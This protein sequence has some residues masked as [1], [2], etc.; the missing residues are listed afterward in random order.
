MFQLP[1]QQAWKHMA[2]GG[3]DTA[4]K[5]DHNVA[6]E[7]GT[8]HDPYF[9]LCMQILLTEQSITLRISSSQNSHKA[10]S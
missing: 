8:W 3:E 4:I 6:A 5:P 10:S 2:Y 1:C 9:Q 7:L